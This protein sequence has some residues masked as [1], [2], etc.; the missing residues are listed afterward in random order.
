MLDIIFYLG[1][2][3]ILVRVKGKDVTFSSSQFGAKHTNIDG[4]KLDYRGV[5]REF[6]DLETATDWREQAI[7]RFKSKI[8]LFNNEEE[9]AEYLINDL[10]KFGYIPKYKQ[11][12]GFRT[13]LIK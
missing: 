2:D 4:L 7:Q 12:A 10:K 1:S 11:K 8:A 5:C 9:I 3:V 13:Q 6:P